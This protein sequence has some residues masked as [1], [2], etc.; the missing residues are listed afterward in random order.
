MGLW[1]YPLIAIILRLSLFAIQGRFGE[2]GL[3]VFYGISGVIVLFFIQRDIRNWLK[4]R[5]PEVKKARE[6]FRLKT[7]RNKE[8]DTE[9]R[10]N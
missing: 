7:N 4:E 10:N 9:T 3:W 1:K 2:V 6:E 5:N 8:N